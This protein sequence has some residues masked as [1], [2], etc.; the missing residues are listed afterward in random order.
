M[1]TT[2]AADPLAVTGTTTDAGAITAGR[3]SRRANRLWI[4]DISQIWGGTTWLYF[5]YVLDHSTGR[6]LGWSP[7]RVPHAEL[8]TD[9]LHQ[10]T[11]ARRLRQGADSRFEPV[12][13]EVPLVFGRGCR[14]AE[15]D[16]PHWAIPSAADV[17]LCEVF[18]GGLR[19]LVDEQEM[20]EDRAWASLPEAQRAIGEWIDVQYNPTRELRDRDPV[21]A[22]A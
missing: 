17:A 18:I 16:I 3:H 1:T 20:S 7:H 8:I 21:A 10:A 14:N 19:R 6:C 2:I 12:D 11:T 15:I 5:A 4:C 22:G 13:S 9:A